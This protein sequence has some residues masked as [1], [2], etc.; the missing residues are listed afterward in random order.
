MPKSAL[1]PSQLTELTLAD[2]LTQTNGV[3]DGG[4]WT[5]LRNGRVT[6]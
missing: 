2:I 5:A 4:R 1:P 3:P 6:M